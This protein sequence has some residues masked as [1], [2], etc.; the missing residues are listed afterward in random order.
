VKVFAQFH[1]S[2]DKTG[3]RLLL[4]GLSRDI[5][6]DVTEISQKNID[7][8]DHS[9]ASIRRVSDGH[10]VI[11]EG[12]S[13]GQ[14]QIVLRSH[15]PRLE[16]GSTRI[17]VSK[18][19]VTARALLADA[20]PGLSVALS[21]G[22]ND[23]QL[24]IQVRVKQIFTS[25]YH[26]GTLTTAVVYSD[27]QTTDIAD[28]SRSDYLLSAWSRGDRY[29]A[30]QPMSDELNRPT[31]SY[32][33]IALDDANKGASVNVELRSPAHCQDPEGAPMLTAYTFVEAAFNQFPQVLEEEKNNP[34]A[35]DISS[36]HPRQM[37]I[38]SIQVSDATAEAE[39]DKNRK[40]SLSD[41]NA[42]QHRHSSSS[43][44][45]SLV[46]VVAVVAMAASVAIINCF[47]SRGRH[48]QSGYKFQRLVPLLS[49]WRGSRDA[50]TSCQDWVWL[51]K[52]QLEGTSIGNGSI[53]SRYSRTSTIGAGDSLEMRTETE[54]V[55]L[56]SASYGSADTAARRSVSYRGSE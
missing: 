13:V 46:V 9:V 45:G 20:V 19:T 17:A 12:V 37:S 24:A 34:K 33:L 51:S 25:K 55:T 5:L 14:T 8:L 4:G 23:D 15:L 48:L 28:M 18:E 38:E 47:V 31:A 53:D 1:V 6:M 41:K 21:S 39:P 43:F 22:D 50:D 26:Q 11:V 2:N 42:V 52:G 54:H 49:K 35:S 29:I 56:G 16:Y 10:R 30:V 27:E 3:E 40:S 36:F 32:R 7:S 44:E